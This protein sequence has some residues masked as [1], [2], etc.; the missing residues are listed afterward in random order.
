MYSIKDFIPRD[1]QEEIFETTKEKSTLVC[2]PTGT[3]KTINIILLAV[4]RLNSIENS[5]IAIVSPTK[6]LNAQHV[7]VFINNTTIPEEEVALVTGAT[8]PEGRKE[9]YGKKVIIATPQ[10]LKEDISNSRFSFKD[11][12]LLAID[13][14]HRAIG[15]YAYNFLAEKYMQDSAFP[16]I[17]ALTA[18]PGGTRVKINEIKSNLHIGAVE[19]R[20][21]E[22]IKEY[23]Q[24]KKTI[25]L[26]VELSPELKQI[27][28][29]I[30]SAFKSRVNDLKKIGFTKPSSL[31]SKRDLLILQQ[32]LRKDLSKK[33][34]STF[35]G[36]SLT[37]SLIKIDYA[38]ELLETQGLIPLQEFW[39][40]LQQEET[41][42]AKAI[43][44]MEEVQSA[45]SMTNSLI[46]KNTK[47]P[48][49][50]ILRGIIRNEL[51]K[52]P[53]A[54]FI[55]F[56]NYRNTIEEIIEFLNMEKGIKATKL[57]GQK[58]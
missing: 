49:L 7:K 53:K 8:K 36:I 41:K 25:W 9:L 10:T 3:G 17:L 44:K 19:I 5:K 55:V 2:L 37:A 21:E 50:Y 48:K 32:Q 4:H 15:N 24:E 31:I 58:S 26:E 39:N 28:S 46:E 56:A 6:P 51:E 11:F 33:N 43:L 54:K 29:L 18:S 20:T 34:P 16:L 23:I 13:E 45:I 57:I 12:S 35:Y 42:A 40:K 22:D 1:Y 30:K 47:H 14:A 27:Q 38:L 52:N